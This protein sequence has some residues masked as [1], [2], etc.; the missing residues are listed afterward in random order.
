MHWVGP[1]QCN[2]IASCSE[3]ASTS[4][5]PVALA[6]N[7]LTAWVGMH[8]N[9]DDR[10]MRFHQGLEYYISIRCLQTIARKNEMDLGS[11]TMNILQLTPSECLPFLRAIVATAL[12]DAYKNRRWAPIRPGDSSILDRARAAHPQHGVVLSEVVIA[13]VFA[14][15]SDRLADWQEPLSREDYYDRTNKFYRPFG[16]RGHEE[17]VAL[18]RKSLAA[19]MSQESKSYIDNCQF[20]ALRRLNMKQVN[21]LI[22]RETNSSSWLS[23]IVINDIASLLGTQYVCLDDQWMKASSNGKGVPV[24][25]A[26]AAVLLTALNNNPRVLQSLNGLAR[27]LKMYSGEG[28]L[29]FRDCFS[30]LISAVSL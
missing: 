26:K 9:L 17:Y 24:S 15:S 25:D 19:F 8:S 18:F 13:R 30:A 20:H 23:H 1:Y 3:Q 10:L 5:T 16:R 7:T 11:V 21:R 6:S 29:W 28:N 4:N 12:S 14:V 22:G 27:A 2:G